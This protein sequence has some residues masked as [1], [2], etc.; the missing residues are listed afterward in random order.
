VRI[1]IIQTLLLAAV[2]AALLALE[3]H[4]TIHGH[5]YSWSCGKT[6]E[7]GACSTPVGDIK[8]RFVATV[9]Q[10]AFGTV[11]DSRGSY[12]L[13]LPAGRYSV[14][15]QWAGGSILMEAGPSTVWVPPFIDVV[16]DY[17]IRGGW[18]AH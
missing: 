7:A 5:V 18:A 10:R 9:G 11:T 2:V 6:L 16:A 12:S 4:G 14:T 1:L 13:E 3:Q 17:A 8:L 15:R